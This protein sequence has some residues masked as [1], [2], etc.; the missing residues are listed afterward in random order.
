MAQ[1][2]AR[3]WPA[4][5]LACNGQVDCASALCTGRIVFVRPCIYHFLYSR[6]S[7]ISASVLLTE[8]S[9]DDTTSAVYIQKFAE[10][11]HQNESTRISVCHEAL[12]PIGAGVVRARPQDNILWLS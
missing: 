8:S 2:V 3:V 9:Y 12:I 1:L 6:L 11:A 5:S 10:A 7:C 4:T